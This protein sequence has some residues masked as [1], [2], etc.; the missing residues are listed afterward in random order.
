[1]LPFLSAASLHFLHFQ[2]KPLGLEDL[3]TWDIHSL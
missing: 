3:E 1:M 2:A